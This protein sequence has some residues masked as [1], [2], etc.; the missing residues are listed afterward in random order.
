MTRNMPITRNQAASST[1][2]DGEEDTL[3]SRT[4][5]GRAPPLVGS[6]KSYSGE[7]SQSPC[8]ETYRPFGHN[9]SMKKS[10]KPLSLKISTK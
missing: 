9:L 10:T 8:R 2:D 6:G 1:N 5:G 4:G 3:Q 7:A